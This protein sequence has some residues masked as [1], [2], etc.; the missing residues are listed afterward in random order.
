MLR[1]VLTPTSGV[2]LE[3]GKDEVEFR[4]EY[5]FEIIRKVDIT[6]EVYYPAKG[7]NGIVTTV[8]FAHIG[9]MQDAEK[10]GYILFANWD[11]FLGEY[12]LTGGKA[13][14]KLVSGTTRTV[15]GEEMAGRERKKLI[16]SFRNYAP[17]LYK[18]LAD[19]DSDVKA[20]QG[21]KLGDETLDVLAVATTAG[22]V[23]KA[24]GQ[25]IN[26]CVNICKEINTTAHLAVWRRYLRTVWLHE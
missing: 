23:D 15:H 5:F 24:K 4:H 25:L 8:Y 16:E 11:A 18:V 13:N 2:E 22:C 20:V 12:F 26:T 14:E 1:P 6:E 19:E 9:I 7:K 21:F 10:D 17:S 3:A